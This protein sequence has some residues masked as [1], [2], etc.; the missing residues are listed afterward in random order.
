[1][2]DLAMKC[3]PVAAL[4]GLLAAAA[5]R[6]AL[7]QNYFNEPTGY[8]AGDVLVHLRAIG[9]IPENFSSSVSV[10]GGHVS[11]TNQVTPEVDLAYFLTP[12]WSVEAIAATSRHEVSATGTALGKVDVGSVWVLPPTITL[13]Y[14]MPQ[15]GPFRP[16]AGVGLSVIFF[17]DSHAAGPTVDKVGYNIGVGPALDAGFDV[18]L[19]GRWVANFDVKQ[20]FVS[21]EARINHSAVIAKTALSPTVIGAGIGYVF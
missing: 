13:Q 8:Q 9:V 2:G 20:M 1:M 21:T 10:I 15:I 19:K 14:H 6:P 16:Y 18:P 17:Y 5:F 4:A 11:T 12:H 3:L 7:A